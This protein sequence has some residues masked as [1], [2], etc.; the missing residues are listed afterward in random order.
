MTAASSMN[1]AFVLLLSLVV[2]VAAQDNTLQS[3][4]NGIIGASVGGTLAG[5]LLVLGVCYWRK[6]C[7][8]AERG[9]PASGKSSYGGA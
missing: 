6:V 9:T 4:I 2:L 3:Y 1:F 7:C 8:F 5:F